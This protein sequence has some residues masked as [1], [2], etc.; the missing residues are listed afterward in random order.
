MAR[1]DRAAE[2][3]GYMQNDLM[4][5]SWNGT[6]LTPRNLYRSRDAL[7]DALGL[8]PATIHEMRKAATTHFT[9]Q[10]MLAGMYSPKV[11]SA[12]LGHSDDGIALQVYTLLNQEDYMA[13][14][15]SLSEPLGIQMGMG[16]NVVFKE[17]DADF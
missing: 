5:P 9:A 7:I 11:V 12:R 6:P 3:K 10:Q 2:R 8:P 4:F 13:A 16:E 1:M 14:T 17:E 15:L